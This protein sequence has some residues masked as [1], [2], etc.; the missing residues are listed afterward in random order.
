MGLRYHTQQPD[1]PFLWLIPSHHPQ[2]R[3]SA[4]FRACESSRLS[5]AE[6]KAHSLPTQLTDTAQQLAAQA[7]SQNPTNPFRLRFAYKPAG[8][9]NS[10]TSLPARPDQEGSLLMREERSK[11]VWGKQSKAQAQAGVRTS[12]PA[13][14]TPPALP[15]SPDSRRTDTPAPAATPAAMRARA[16]SLPIPSL[17]PKL[18]LSEQPKHLT[19]SN[20]RNR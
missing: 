3:L 19:A 1:K 2:S 17:S 20:Q 18:Y 11:D 16:V 5:A 10:S 14:L 15:L 4:E 8:Q 7:S 12:I 9:S 6:I 13:P